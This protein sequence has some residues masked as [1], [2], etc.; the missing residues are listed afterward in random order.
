M[1]PATAHVWS[2]LAHSGLVL[3]WAFVIAMPFGCRSNTELIEAELRAKERQLEEMRALLDCRNCQI[4]ALEMDIA[5]LRRQQMQLPSGAAPLCP[6]VQ[7]L[8]LGRL[9]GGVDLDPKRPGDEALQIL[10][11]PLDCDGQSVKVPGTLQVQALEITPQGIKVPLSTWQIS[12]RDLRQKWDDPIFGQPAYRITLPWKAWPM[13]RR[14][15]VVA[16][17]I[18][19]DE[20]VFE[21]EKDVEIELPKPELPTVSEVVPPHPAS[22][23]GPHTPQPKLPDHRPLMPPPPPDSGSKL[24]PPKKGSTSH[25]PVGLRPPTRGRKR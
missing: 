1:K 23:P 10:V 7:S 9:T 8:A 6:A 16:R 21:A 12:S 13:T 14:L 15:R 22:P 18:T 20:Q 3:V 5:R 4:Q 24:I 19:P 25:P 17:F 11:E 2:R